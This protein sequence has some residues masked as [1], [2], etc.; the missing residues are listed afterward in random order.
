MAEN[1][2]KP[3]SA[4]AKKITSHLFFMMLELLSIPLGF[5]KLIV[6]GKLKLGK[7]REST[8]LH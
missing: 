5:Q 4:S 2:Q 6:A 7:F 8:P 3:Q 1:E